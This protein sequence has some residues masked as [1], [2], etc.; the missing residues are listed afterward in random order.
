MPKTKHPIGVFY[1][2]PDHLDSAYVRLD[3]QHELIV[4]KSDEGVVLDVWKD[5]GDQDG[6][7]WSTYHFDNEMIPDDEE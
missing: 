7:V 1:T 4:H 5:G 3:E 6:P 2:K